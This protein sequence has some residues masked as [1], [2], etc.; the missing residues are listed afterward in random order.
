MH[1]KY[2]ALSVGEGQTYLA[3]DREIKDIRNNSVAGLE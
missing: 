2:C 1:L 3:E